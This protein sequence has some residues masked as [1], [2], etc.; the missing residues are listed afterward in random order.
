MDIADEAQVE[1]DN[2]LNHYLRTHNSNRRSK[3]SI[4]PE[5]YC[6]NCYEEVVSNKLFCNGKCATEFE[7]RN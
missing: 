7:K 6:H 3:P 5:G 4:S 2:N 1:I